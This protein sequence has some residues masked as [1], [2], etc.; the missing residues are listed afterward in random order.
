MAALS[1]AYAPE[2]VDLRD[3]RA[4][5]LEPVLIEEGFTWRSLL[6]WDFTPSAELVRRFVNIQALNGYALMV[7]RR[8]VGYGYYV[9]EDRKALLGDLY[10]LRDFSSAE[11]EDRLLAAMLKVLLNTPY[12]QRVE[13]QLLMLRTAFDRALPFGKFARVQ[14]R[15]FMLADLGSLA[16]LRESPAAALYSFTTWTEARHDESAR[17]IACAYDGHIDSTINDQYRSYAG[18]K[19]FLTNIV[20]YPGCGSF[21]EGASF[22]AEDATGKIV[23]LSL[24]SLIAPEVGHITQI[25]VAPELQGRTI[26]YELMRRSLLAFSEVGCE[27]TSLT[28]TASNTGAIRLYQGMG[29]RALRRFGSFVW[30]G[31]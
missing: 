14:P 21:F 15:V 6:S 26:G 4:E 16:D 24:G 11:N 13:A 31:F 27:K 20:Q 17:L 2:V 18:A 10:V 29:F 12:L 1:D 23:G 7:G 3:L 19:R 28:V 25:C 22:T 8:I 5:D 9:C 30:E